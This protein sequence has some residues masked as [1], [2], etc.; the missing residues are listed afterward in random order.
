MFVVGD[1]LRP[2]IQKKQF[3]LLYA[4]EAFAHS[5]DPE[6]FFQAAVRLLKPGGRLVLCDD[7]LSGSGKD[8]VLSERKNHWLNI[9]Q[10]G[11]GV[12]GL[13]APK[14][15]QTLAKNENLI[16]IK[17]KNLTPYLLL[18]PLP[19]V[20]VELLSAGIGIIAGKNL[21]LQSVI[22][23]QTLQLCLANGIVEY[24]YLVFEKQSE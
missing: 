12:N 7:F 16:C 9:F 5:A 15:V 23:R 14:Y 10:Q 24:D 4:I 8:V 17:R 22:G 18:K 2:P 19:K 3:D 20:I 11:W 1:F 21:Y 6:A 13:W